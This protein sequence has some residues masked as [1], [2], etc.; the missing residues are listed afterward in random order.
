M[1]AATDKLKPVYEAETTPNWS[2]VDQSV[3]TIHL[4]SL[5]GATASIELPDDLAEQFQQLTHLRLWNLQL[6]RIP[7]LPAG[8]KVLEVR[9]CTALTSLPVLPKG[10]EVLALEELPS[11]AELPL[12]PED[13]FT[14]LWDLSIQGCR[15][16]TAETLRSFPACCPALRALDLSKCPQLDHILS[17]Q[18]GLESI[19]LRN[20]AQ[21]RSLPSSWPAEL[22]M[23]DLEGCAALEELGKDRLPESVDYLDLSGTKSLR[24]LPLPLGRPRT[25]YVNN[26]GLLLPGEIL[27]G[28]A[29][30]NR[31]A[32]VWPHLAAVK[33]ADCEV[34]VILL[35]N[36]RA[37][38]T[39][40][41]RVL[42]DPPDKFDE[43]EDSTHG[44]RLWKFTVPYKPSETI[45]A[46]SAPGGNGQGPPPPAEV[47]VNVWDFAGQDFY[48]RTHRI[49]LQ[50]KAVFVLCDT[51]AG[52]GADPAGDRRETGLLL[53]GWDENRA[54][55]YWRDQVESLVST[56]SAKPP[57][58]MV[59]TKCDRDGEPGM[60]QRIQDLKARNATATEGHEVIDFSA[61]TEA[62]ARRLLDEIATKA[63]LVLGPPSQHAMTLGV[64][65]VKE[66]LREMM[67]A[68]E[69]AHKDAERVN[70]TLAEGEPRQAANP[71]HPTITTA[72][73]DEIIKE[74]CKDEEWDNPGSVIQV[75]HESGFLYYDEKRFPKTVIL[76]QRWV[77]NGIYAAFERN[78]AWPNLLARDGRFTA[79]EMAQWA[80]N[81]LDYTPQQQETFLKFM[82]SCETAY[83][84]GPRRIDSEVEYLV[85][86]ALPEYS[87]EIEKTAQNRRTGSRQSTSIP[88][89]HKYLSRDSVL[90]LM[91][92]LGKEWGR[93]PLL[94]RWGGQFES[95]RPWRSDEAEETTFV[96]L[97]WSPADGDSQRYGGVLN[98]TQYGPDHSFLT[99]ILG[100]CRAIPG[101]E[102][103]ESNPLAGQ[104][105]RPI[106]SGDHTGTE[107]HK[108]KG[109]DLNLISVG[110]SFAGEDNGG[111]P[112]DWPLGLTAWLETN[113]R[114]EVVN[115]ER[116]KKRLNAL[117]EKD[118]QKYLD[119][120]AACDYVY[121]FISRKY[122]KSEY[123]MYEFL[124]T[125][126][127]SG[128]GRAQPEFVTLFRYEDAYW[129]TRS[130]DYES[131]ISAFEDFWR[132]WA[133]S[134]IEKIEGQKRRNF[135]EKSE[136]LENRPYADW[137]RAITT[138]ELF[139]LIVNAISGNKWQYNQ[140][141]VQPG[142][143]DIQ[144]WADQLIR[145][146][147]SSQ[148]FFRAAEDAW[149][150]RTPGEKQRAKRLLVA[151][152]E[153]DAPDAKGEEVERMLDQPLGDDGD[154]DRNV[155]RWAVLLKW[156]ELCKNT[157]NGLPMGWDDLKASL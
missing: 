83:S 70:A 49:F 66:K 99:A 38:K 36:G 145:H 107:D 150:K 93:T 108:P 155:I 25:L 32:I 16:L 19:R 126:Q 118:R 58:I 132:G 125:W 67:A 47:T 59:R 78:S 141:A 112:S 102:E 27:G 1:P 60:P 17:W 143:D 97:N 20:C 63:S 137:I 146:S 30:A 72:E 62:N 40:M 24:E 55:Q 45:D 104:H 144:N 6:T 52:G 5:D 10:L 76:D 12:P 18:G 122:L 44:I 11:L 2:I 111:T 148:N 42:S 153:L 133:D 71:P 109:S 73:L 151:G 77:I 92:Q 37:G 120:V 156:R 129:S 123:C 82:L 96:H 87:E 80:W 57:M 15:A 61:K 130:E 29:K 113:L 114:C 101:F 135:L 41:M 127:R 39:S 9:K 8:L 95:F 68:N 89:S 65:K 75:L 105:L 117:Q 100:K 128:P 64:L 14:S 81:A 131:E 31:A 90:S 85:P 154:S 88:L 74:A 50:S 56:G 86:Q 140:I 94:W 28:D 138:N 34:K 106:S 21:L 22:G 121:V 124:K 91:V 7:A 84:L 79:P 136:R 4:G 46:A 157:G 103:L 116:E 53:E 48:H 26:T 23:L 98:V 119:R 149:K 51:A 3:T 139:K 54:L 43:K 69:K 110:I 134:I 152:F 35:G 147:K 142:P 33:K 13:N 115:Y